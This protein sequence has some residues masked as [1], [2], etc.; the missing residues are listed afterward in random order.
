M[1]SCR[2]WK[3]E[4]SILLSLSIPAIFGNSLEVSFW[5]VDA[6]ML[7]HYGVETLAVAV[8]GNTVYSIIWSFLE[9]MLTAQDTLV[10]YSYGKKDMKG[11]SFNIFSRW[12]SLTYLLTYLIVL[13]FGL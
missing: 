1:L 8:V 3:E 10:A 9:G 6:I 13:D 2:L 4:F 11:Y 7:G 5:L 12:Y